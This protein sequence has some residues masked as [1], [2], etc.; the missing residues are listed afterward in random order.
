MALRIL[1]T[2]D[3]HLG[4]TFYEYDRTHEHSAFLEW[5]KKTMLNE[6]VD[7]MLVCGDIFDVSNPSAVSLSMFYNFLKDVNRLIPHLQV[8]CVAGN[9]DSA[10]RLESP[11]MLLE[12]F[13]VHVVGVVPRTSDGEIDYAQL[14]IPLNNKNGDCEALCMAIPFL[15]QGDYPRSQRT[16]S[17]YSD[18]IATIY[19]QAAEYAE[20]KRGENQAVIA[21]G[22]LHALNAEISGDDKSERVIMGGIEFIPVEAFPE[23]VS[24]MALGHIHKAQCVGNKEDIR[25]SGSPLP[26]SFSEINYKHQVVLID[27]ENGQ[28]GKIS[29]LETPVTVRLLNVPY[30]A[31]SPVEVLDELK[32]LPDSDGDKTYAPYL[33][34][35]VLLNSPEPHLR[36]IIETAV[37]NKHAKLARID[38]QYEGRG[39]YEK[40]KIVSVDELQNLNPLDMLTQ[41]YKSR[42]D[43]EIP[44]ELKTLFNIAVEE[45]NA[46]EN[47][48]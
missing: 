21:T 12:V 17:T 41:K 36:N 48:N 10:T 29:S 11:K 5:L 34:V 46:E 23:S 30:R 4:Q 2:A 43:A 13:N 42:F 35:K 37:E 8:V 45:A 19:Q 26:M 1:H 28:I 38:V 6:A 27:V 32:T 44:E 40:G 33:Q 15:R 22:H 20:K 24:Y 3:W 31:K 25:Y 7:V 14:C 47:N 18:G 39:V 9:H 16:E